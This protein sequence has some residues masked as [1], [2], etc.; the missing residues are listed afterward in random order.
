MGD[1]PFWSVSSDEL[2]RQLHTSRDGL[3]S[4]A[5][6]ERYITGARSRLKPHHD[7][8]VLFLLLSQFRSP[9]ILILLFAVVVSMF[10]ADRTDALIILTIVFVDTPPSADRLTP[11]R[12]TIAPASLALPLLIPLRH[13]GDGLPSG[14]LLKCAL[15]LLFSRESQLHC[16]QRRKQDGYQQ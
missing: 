3:S 12:R 10:L 5:A 13:A 9:I 7:I 1:E 14:F 15:A 11:A 6:R 16:K 2:L 4:E 8:S